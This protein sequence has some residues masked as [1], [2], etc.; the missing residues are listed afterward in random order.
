M[1]S[2]SP[3]GAYFLYT[4]QQKLAEPLACLICPNTGSTICFLRR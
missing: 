2:M 3:F 4:A 1:Q